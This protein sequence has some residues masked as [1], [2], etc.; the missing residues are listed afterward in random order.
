MNSSRD[1]LRPQPASVAP[2]TL[3]TGTIDLSAGPRPSTMSDRERDRLL[4]SVE[5]SQANHAV[6]RPSGQHQE[7]RRLT[8][9]SGSAG[10]WSPRQQA[11][12]RELAHL[13]RGALPIRGLPRGYCSHLAARRGEIGPEDAK[14]AQDAWDRYCD[15]MDQV[16]AWCSQR[17]AD[18]LRMVIVY[19]EPSTLA[20]AP[21]VRE[22][23]SFLGDYWRMR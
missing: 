14:A 21:L 3:A 22:A 6:T 17:H 20:R 4:S 7:P 16:S 10:G 9:D 1:R 5:S 19:G 12:A 2:L 18:A 15:A 23:L 8:E 11:A 13:W